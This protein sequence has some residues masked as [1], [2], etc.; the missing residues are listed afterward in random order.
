MSTHQ[1]SLPRLTILTI[2]GD[3]HSGVPVPF[4]FRLLTLMEG[5]YSA[6]YVHELLSL[7]ALQRLDVRECCY[8]EWVD[9]ETGQ[10][11][12]EERGKT[13]SAEMARERGVEL[14]WFTRRR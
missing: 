1:P 11:L 4:P 2:E 5:M 6:Q 14:L 10:R 8:N 9:Y 3:S 12:D 7:T 13:T